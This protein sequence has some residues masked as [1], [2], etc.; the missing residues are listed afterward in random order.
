MAFLY[1]KGKI[2]S[3]FSNSGL[4]QKLLFMSKMLSK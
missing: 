2:E 3:K 4:F 1:Q